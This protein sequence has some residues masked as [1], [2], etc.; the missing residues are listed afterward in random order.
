MVNEGAFYEQKALE[1][2]KRNGYRVVKKNFRSRFGEI[3]I[4]AKGHGGISFIEVKARR[5][6]AQVQGR[7]TVDFRKRERIRKTALVFTAGAKDVSFRFD[8]LEIVQGSG[9]RE[10][11]FI[12]DAFTMN[13]DAGV[14]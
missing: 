12:E 3:D 2:L 11:N 6:G 9:W 8:V 10:Y 14:R 13:T 7:E 4:I 1:F 5:K